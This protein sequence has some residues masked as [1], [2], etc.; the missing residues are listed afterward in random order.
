MLDGKKKRVT[1]ASALDIRSRLNVKNQRQTLKK[2][3]KDNES[4]L[5]RVDWFLTCSDVVPIGVIRCQ[6]LVC[7]CLHE[8]SPCGN[9]YLRM[10]RTEKY[11]QVTDKAYGCWVLLRA[12]GLCT[13][14]LLITVLVYLPGSLQMRCI[15]LHKFV[16]RHVL[17]GHPMSSRHV[18]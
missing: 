17:D 7:A 2:H 16:R 13:P 18:L 10:D 6:L 1:L 4:I 11:S 3:F 15:R 14:A 9:L 12:K 8:I 5:R